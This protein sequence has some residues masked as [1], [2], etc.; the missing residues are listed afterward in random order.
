MKKLLSFVPIALSLLPA[1]LL[2]GCG[3][4]PDEYRLPTQEFAKILELD[5]R[6]SGTLFG[7]ILF[8]S[9]YTQRSVRFS[10]SDRT[11]VSQ[12]DGRFVVENIPVGNHKLFIQVKNYEPISQ[13]VAIGKEAAV[14]AGPWRLKLA[15]GKVIGRL[16]GENGKSAPNVEMRLVPLGGLA[17]T[18]SDGIF[19]FI[20]VNSG[21][22]T[23]RV[24]DSQF[25]TYNRQFS[26]YKGE[27]R[28]LGNIKVFR[29]AGFNMPRAAVMKMRG[30]A[31]PAIK[32]ISN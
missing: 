29:K 23:L 12:P 5:G 21:N 25:F 32:D 20:G 7:R 18:D 24:M 6:D 22:H 17:K 15:R 10:L 27:Q 13:A 8:P 11:F 31:Q 16:V 9:A 3:D 2:A 14:Q 26:L 4:L 19:Q 1:L 28:N 30:D